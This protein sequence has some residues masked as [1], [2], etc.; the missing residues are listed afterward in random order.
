[1]K[2]VKCPYCGQEQSVSNLQPRCIKCGKQIV[3]YDEKGGEPTLVEDADQEVYRCPHCKHMQYGQRETC[4][5]C[6]KSMRRKNYFGVASC[7]ALYLLVMSV[8]LTFI[9]SS[10]Y[11]LILIAAIIFFCARAHDSAKKGTFIVGREARAESRYNVAQANF[12]MVEGVADVPVITHG[13][14]YI[15]KKHSR[16]VLDFPSKKIERYVR[17]SQVVDCIYTREGHEV[18]K[19]PVGRAVVGAV[20]AGPVGAVVGAVS[21]VG[22]KNKATEYVKILYHPLSNLQDTREIV[23]VDCKVDAA[24]IDALDV[25]MGRKQNTLK[26]QSAKPTDYL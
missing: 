4:D 14:V 16:F 6:G 24:F 9:A 15:E 25:V 3:Q 7:V 22:T 21:G 17:F 11:V 10:G 19:S 23:L 5:V 26:S 18:H 8:L 12:S 2:F 13:T 1:M 20:V